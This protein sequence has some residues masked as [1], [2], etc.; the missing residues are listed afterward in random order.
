[1]VNNIQLCEQDLLNRE[2]LMLTKMH[3]KMSHLL[4]QSFLTLTAPNPNNPASAPC[5]NICA[6][7]S[8]F[9][10]TNQPTQKL[11]LAGNVRYMVLVLMPA[12]SDKNRLQVINPRQHLPA[13]SMVMPLV[14]SSYPCP[15]KVGQHKVCCS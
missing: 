10:N 5:Y 11:Y 7:C 1:M 15:D 14:V 6:G 12:V 3:N 9:G 8:N 2:Q 13:C 4:T